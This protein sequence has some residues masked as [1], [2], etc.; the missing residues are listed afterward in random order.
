MERTD[1]ATPETSI[2]NHQFSM[3]NSQSAK[4][5]QPARCYPPPDAL[6]LTLK[7]LLII[8]LI[9]ILILS[10]CP[11]QPARR[12]PALAFPFLTRRHHRIMR[13]QRAVNARLCKAM[14]G[15]AR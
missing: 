15:Y 9:L 13:G 12:V 1:M 3:P 6:Q 7:E 14:R 2:I 10:F 4:N 11:N 8:I 5:T